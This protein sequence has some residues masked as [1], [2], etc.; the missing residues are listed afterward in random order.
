[1]TF[2]VLKKVAEIRNYKPQ[3]AKV[4]SRSK[5]IKNTIL[6]NTYDIAVSFRD[7]H[8]RLLRHPSTNLDGI[9]VTAL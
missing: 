3:N 2:R 1:M 9:S 5:K 4:Y 6:S 7:W 8:V